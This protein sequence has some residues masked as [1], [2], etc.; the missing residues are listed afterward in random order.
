MAS[1]YASRA[2]SKLPSCSAAA[3]K[4]LFRLSVPELLAVA[5]EALS[6]CAELNDEGTSRDVK[7]KSTRF[8][9]KVPPPIGA[10][11]YL[12]R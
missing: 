9:A 6:E 3:S 12:K 11:A 10:E 2:D 1:K 7:A 5:A 4:L 8:H